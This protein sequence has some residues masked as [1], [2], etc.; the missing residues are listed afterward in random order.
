MTLKGTR[1][2]T[3]EPGDRVR[4]TGDQPYRDWGYRLPIIGLEGWIEAATPHGQ[5]TVNTEDGRH[6]YFDPDHLQP[7]TP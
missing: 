2:Q 1:Q 4:I 3:F 6:F 5:Y 7:V